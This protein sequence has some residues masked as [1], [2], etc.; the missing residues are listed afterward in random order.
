VRQ[1]SFVEALG[2]ALIEPRRLHAPQFRDVFCS[3]LE[4]VYA[5][6]RWPYA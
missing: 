4:V 2:L 6:I 1:E 5:R 3:T